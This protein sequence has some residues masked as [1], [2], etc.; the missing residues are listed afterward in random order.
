MVTLVEC[1]CFNWYFY[2]FH[3]QVRVF[4]ARSEDYQ[5]SEGLVSA[6]SQT[7]SLFDPIITHSLIV[8]L[9]ILGQ[10]GC[11]GYQQFV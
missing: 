1:I 11:H 7:M 8:H 4:D 10:V 3:S 5:W 6:V 2:F 9:S